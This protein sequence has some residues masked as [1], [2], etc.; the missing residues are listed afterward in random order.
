MP[1]E[2]TEFVLC[3]LYHCTP[4][5]LDEQDSDIVTIHLAIWN[6]RQSYTK[7]KQKMNNR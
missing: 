1:P 4:K 7:A 6:A 2:Y 3:E 5:E